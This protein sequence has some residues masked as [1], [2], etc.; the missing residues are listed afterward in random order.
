MERERGEGERGRA[1]SLVSPLVLPEFRRL[2]TADVISLLGDWA[3]RLALT[4][5]VLE[6]TGSPGWAAAV[7]AVSLAGFVGIGQVL[8][9]FADRF[10]RIPVMLAADVARAALFAAMLLHVPVGVLLLFAFLAG[11]ATPPFEAARSAALPEVVPEH[12][13]GDAL[14]LSGITVQASIVVGN[15]LGGVLLVLVGARGALAI[16]AASFLVS[17]VLVL[18]LRGTAAASPAS[19]DSSVGGSLRAGASNLFGDRM[20]RRALAIIATTGALGTVGEA[21]VVPYAR[22]VGLGKG[23]VGL[24]AA[25]VPV[26]TLIGT[27]V[28][29]RSEDHRTLLRHAGICTLVT[30][31][32]AVPLFWLE[33]GGAG[34]FVAF[35]ICGG[36][37]A[38]SIPTNV[39]IGTR[40]HRESRASAMGIAVGI[41]MGGQA[42]G[43]AV[44]GVVASTVGP[45]RAIAGALT[46]AAAFGAWSTVTTPIDARHLAGRRR[47]MSS[48]A[49]D[50]APVAPTASDDVRSVIDLDDV[51]A[52]TVVDLA[53]AEVSSEHRS[54][55][56]SV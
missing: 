40:L 5:V 52:P 44:G 12:R 51:T 7:T 34:A 48:I 35:I 16:N 49:P 17:A 38:V 25:S 9:T 4:V 46:L 31:A 54:S 26:G 53:G 22:T 19:G 2:W 3:G 45:P 56:V 37:F 55:R 23:V 6:R 32:L 50:S 20:A 41:L 18:G 1:R 24:L 42:A 29:A 27:A 28:I 11:L 21:L 15:A 47:P 13:Y 10:G 39:V 43:A 36:I 14:A 33:V 30:S 8:A